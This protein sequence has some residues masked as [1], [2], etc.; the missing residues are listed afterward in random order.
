MAELVSAEQLSMSVAV[1]KFDPP[2]PRDHSK[3]HVSELINR[4]A[5]VTGMAPSYDNEPTQ[6]GWNIMALGRGVEALLRP[7]LIHEAGKKEWLFKPQIVYTKDDIIGSLDGELHSYQGIEAIVEMKSKHSS[8]SDP[9][10]NWRYMAQCQAYCHMAGCS[11]AWMPVLYLPRRGP[12]N[13]EL[14]LYQ[15][16]FSESEIAD[17]WLTLKNCK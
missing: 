14:H 11:T 15:K 2:E 3:V 9:T 5:K 17:L 13:A 12:P 16:S 4:A 10:E 8:P 7:M 6:E 1:D